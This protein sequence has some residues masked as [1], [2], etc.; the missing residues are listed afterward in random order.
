METDSTIKNEPSA[1]DSIVFASS[2]RPRSFHWVR[3]SRAPRPAQF[4]GAGREELRGQQMYRRSCFARTP[5]PSVPQS[6]C[7]LSLP[8]RSSL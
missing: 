5:M 2:D 6:S 7:P 8:R 1:S 3:S 4:L